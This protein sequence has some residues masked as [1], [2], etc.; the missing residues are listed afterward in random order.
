MPIHADLV[1]SGT[2]IS[3]LGGVQNRIRKESKGRHDDGSMASGSS[4][5][6][7]SNSKK[8]KKSTGLRGIRSGVGEFVRGKSDQ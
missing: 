7:S 3:P 1:K 6:G 2:N 5:L 4:G 8:E